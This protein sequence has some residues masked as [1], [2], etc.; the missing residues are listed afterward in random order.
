MKEAYNN[1]GFFSNLLGLAL[2]N[3]KYYDDAI[4][5]FE[6]AISIDPC[7]KEAY[8]NK[9]KMGMISRSSIKVPQKLWRGGHSIWS[10]DFVRYKFQRGLH[11]QR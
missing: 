7:L 6:K 11:Q 9:G 5:A 8:N 10:S 1:K 3:L 2:K 4:L